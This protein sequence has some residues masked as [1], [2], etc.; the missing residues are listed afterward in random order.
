MKEKARCIL[1]NGQCRKTCA[2]YSR[3]LE[4]TRST[5]AAGIKFDPQ[6]SRA[7][8]ILTDTLANPIAPPELSQV[9][10]LCEKEPKTQK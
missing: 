6:R 7:I 2:L 1:G 9:Q 10:L 4:A 8:T 5:E 3:S